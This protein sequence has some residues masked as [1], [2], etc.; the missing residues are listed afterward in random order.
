MQT[1]NVVWIVSAVNFWVDTVYKYANYI[2]SYTCLIL[3]L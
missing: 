2:P 1:L 3:S